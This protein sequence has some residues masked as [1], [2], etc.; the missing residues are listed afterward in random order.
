MKAKWQVPKID[1][2]EHV[3]ENGLRVIFH[4][5]NFLTITYRILSSYGYRNGDFP[6]AVHLLEHMLFKPEEKVFPVFQQI[7]GDING[8]VSMDEFSI[9]WTIPKVFQDEAIA[10]VKNIL[11]QNKKL[12]TEHMLEKEKFVII[13]EIG[14][15]FSNPS[16][17]L[18]IFLRKKIFGPDAPGTHSPEQIEKA[19]RSVKLDDIKQESENIS[20]EISVMSIVGDFS[21]E[22]VRKIEIWNGKKIEQKALKPDPDY[23]I[24][25]EKRETTEDFIGIA[26]LGPSRSTPDS[27]I[28]GLFGA[29]M[30]A[31]PTSR[32]YRKLRLEKGLVYYVSAGNV[33]FID[34]GYFAMNTATL[35]KK[36]QEVIEIIKN[37]IA[38]IID[39]GITEEELETIKNIFF[40]T[41]Y[42]M[43]DTKTT[44]SGVLAYG[45]LFFGDPLRVYKE[46]AERVLKLKIKD[47]QK[48]VAKY[49]D[50]EKMVVC[51]VGK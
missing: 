28:M 10:A 20:P 49:L 27:E 48:V 31:F 51:I 35:P 16:S 32:L 7:G 12:W 36:T 11:T 3:L 45:A 19:F 2:E 17:Y 47:V 25:K 9:Y 37:E 4:W 30:T 15:N 1:I 6:E 34:S 23:G 26:W 41:L 38:N 33:S 8:Y 50:P 39:E 43:T 18:N 13:R 21:K 29:M 14:E 46:T 5:K 40:G 24:H 22:A 44:L 42:N